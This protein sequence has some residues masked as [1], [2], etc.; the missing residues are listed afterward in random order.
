M[1]QKCLSLISQ[2][3]TKATVNIA[4]NS[5]P[6]IQFVGHALC[7]FQKRDLK[8]G[9]ARVPGPETEAHAFCLQTVLGEHK[10]GYEARRSHW[11]E[12]QMKHSSVIAMRNFLRNI[13]YCGSAEQALPPNPHHLCRFMDNL[14]LT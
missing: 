12:I 3:T 11:S 5:V 8:K 13:C 4:R 14:V 10:G 9:A 6:Y 2:I 7:H 1:N